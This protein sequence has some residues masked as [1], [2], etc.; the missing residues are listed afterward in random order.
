M[1]ILLSNIKLIC[2]YKEIND[3]N[4]QNGTIYYIDTPSSDDEWVINEQKRRNRQSVI[5][6]VLEETQENYDD[7]GWLPQSD[8][9]N[10]ISSRVMTQNV[11]A[12]KFI[13]EESLYVDI[14]S[15]LDKITSLPMKKCKILTH[16]V[17]IKIS[18][19]T[20][21]SKSENQDANSRRI[22]TK[23]TFL[24]NILSMKSR[25][26]P[27]S[28]YVIGDNIL[29]Y[30]LSTTYVMMNLQNNGDIIGNINGTSVIH[31]TNINPNK[32]IAIK[33][34]NEP[35]TGLNVIKNGSDTYFIGETPTFENRIVWFEIS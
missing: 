34:T 5:N 25:L 22:I 26:G 23:M 14:I 29:E 15:Y 3:I 4:N 31:S 20:S 6:S 12:K 30:L 8:G 2:N 28:V 32:V 35:T 16:D 11:T 13:N 24:N 7:F 9:M 19:D 33:S 1:N 21:L 10:E 17:N 27:A 18:N